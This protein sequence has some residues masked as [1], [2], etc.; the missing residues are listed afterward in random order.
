MLK[1][2]RIILGSLLIAIL[3]IVGCKSKFEQLRLS[4]DKDLKMKKAFEFY[5]NEQYV[6]AQSLLED[7]IGAV[8]G[9]K[10]AEKVYFHYA[11]THYHLQNYSFA[12]YYFKRFSSTFPHGIYAEEALY[13]S[14]DAYYRQSPNYRLTQEDT[15]SAI[16]GLQAFI[17]TYPYSGR[18]DSCNQMIDELRAKLELKALE[19]AKGYFHRKSY[20]AAQHTFKSLLVNYPDTKEVEYIRYM[21]IKSSYKYAQASILGKQ[22][23]RYTEVLEEVEKFKRRHPESQYM[24]EIENYQNTANKKIK[25]IRN[26]L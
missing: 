8:R 19:G 10:D 7:L 12:S 17:N 6:K 3:A 4:N 2:K 5:N 24:K 11:Y 25:K 22:A 13:M 21:I 23:E 1:Q 9:T 16:E 15:E 14:A 20:K 18:V 26:E